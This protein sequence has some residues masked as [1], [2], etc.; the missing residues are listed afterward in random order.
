ML[1]IDNDITMAV[2]NVNA[3]KQSLDNLDKQLQQ[4]SELLD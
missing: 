2:G 1:D 4:T 3:V